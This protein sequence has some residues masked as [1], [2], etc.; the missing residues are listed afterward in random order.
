MGGMGSHPRSPLQATP[1]VLTGV[2]LGLLMAVGR[3]RLAPTALA[4]W[5]EPF[6][7]A[8]GVYGV[9]ALAV[10]GRLRAA[11]GLGL[12]LALLLVG[13]RMPLP[14]G[15]E[16]EP[17]APEWA[18]ALRGCALLPDPVRAP[19]RLL[20]W[21]VSPDKAP[22]LDIPVLMTQ[23]DLVL[24]TGTSD[25]NV[26]ANLQRAL[27]GEVM[28]VRGETP[29]SAMI[30]AVR[31][32]FQYC[33]GDEDHW[34]EDRGGAGGGSRVLVAF[35]EVADVGVIPLVAVRYPGPGGPGGWLD[36]PARLADTTSTVAGVAN[37]LG[38]R[39]MIVAGDLHTPRTFRG[40]S[41]ALHR[42]GLL[43]M[44]APPNWPATVA[45]GGLPG[46]ALHPLDQVWA[47]A[48]WVSAGSST[49]DARGQ[50][51][52]PILVDLAPNRGVAGG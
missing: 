1:L 19:V 34:V 43:S 48:S 15:D 12:G 23:P 47:G 44:P 32:A 38:A 31:G 49:I 5:M 25:S 13:A 27:Q 26:A 21:S 11:M 52:A 8:F 35:P 22:S 51:R 10:G 20:V 16:D 29:E 2:A 24:L 14:E 39:R 9:L 3:D 28:T 6:W 4:L 30:L 36:W 18:D 46:L 17:A 40:L 45:R 42:V 7:L 50:A 37:T 33:G 41:D